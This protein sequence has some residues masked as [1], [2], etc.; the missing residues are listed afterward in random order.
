[1]DTEEKIMT[2]NKKQSN[3][4][5]NIPLTKNRVMRLREENFAKALE[6]AKLKKY[7]CILNKITSKK[8]KKD[9]G[10]LTKQIE[11]DIVK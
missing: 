7:Y 11:H 8:K 10:H 6:I 9:K 5:S 1:M 3:F 2:K 4:I